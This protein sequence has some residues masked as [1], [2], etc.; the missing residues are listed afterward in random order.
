MLISQQKIV[1]DLIREEM[2]Q[3]TALRFRVISGSMAPL[4][5]AG[6]EVV[7]ERASGDRLR[8]GDIVLYTID[9]AFH[10]HRLLARRRHGGATLLVTKGDTALNPD[11]PWRGEQLLGKV[12]A[13]RREDRTIDLGSGKWRVIN[14]LLGVLAALQVA[15]FRGVH[16][17]KMVIVGR[18]PEL[19]CPEQCPELVEGRSRRVEGNR[20]TRWTPLVARIVSAPSRLLIRLAGC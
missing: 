6:D 16:R 14:R 9:G 12:V 18:C 4:I 17:V 5:A 3:G 19:A 11:Q 10:T 13:I 15:A 8:R 7:V 2:A 20:R 1:S